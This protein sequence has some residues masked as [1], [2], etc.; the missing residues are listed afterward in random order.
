VSRARVHPASRESR[1][2]TTLLEVALA[3]VLLIVFTGGALFMASRTGVAYRTDSTGA[4]LDALGTQVLG[5]VAEGLRAADAAGL[6][7]PPAWSPQSTNRVEFTRITGFDDLTG[8]VIPGPPERYVLERDPGDPDD[9]VDNDDDGLI[10]EGRVVWI[11]NFGLAN[12]RR[13]VLCNGVTEDLEGEVG[14]NGLDDNG[15]GLDDEAGFCVEYQWADPADP[16]TRATV[17]LTLARRD[18][19]GRGLITHSYERTIALRN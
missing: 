16:P 1:R 12:E 9:G 18:P 13:A 17:R 5:D 15:N 3:S 7:P 10:D 2:G 4:E 19:R 11:E 6:L 14:G 8:L